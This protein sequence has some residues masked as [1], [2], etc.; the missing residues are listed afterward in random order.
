MT[1]VQWLR[2]LGLGNG[3]SGGY[4]GEKDEVNLKRPS[5]RSFY[6]LLG[7]RTATR[8]ISLK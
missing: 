4:G 3:S 6:K 2:W 8:H 7:S 1:A 5:P